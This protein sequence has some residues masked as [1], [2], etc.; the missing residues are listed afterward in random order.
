MKECNLK[1]TR[2]SKILCTSGG[3]RKKEIS[4]AFSD[5]LWVGAPDQIKE[6]IENTQW[7]D[8]VQVRAQ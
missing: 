2:N 1:T 3:A 8:M 6:R 7:Q 5:K 4:A